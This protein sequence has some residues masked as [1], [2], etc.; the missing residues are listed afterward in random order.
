MKIKLI[1]TSQEQIYFIRKKN[2]KNVD[3]EN[4]SKIGMNNLTLATGL[5]AMIIEAGGNLGT[6]TGALTVAA[7]TIMAATWADLTTVQDSIILTTIILG[8][9]VVTIAGEVVKIMEKDMAAVGQMALEEGG[10]E[11]PHLAKMLIPWAVMV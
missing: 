1:F 5:E 6:T 10:T 8:V 7:V 2:S 4:K 3:V 9:E 11:V